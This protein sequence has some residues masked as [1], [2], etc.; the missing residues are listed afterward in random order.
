MRMFLSLGGVAY[1][2]GI[3]EQCEVLSVKVVCML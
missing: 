2:V 3:Y 1:D